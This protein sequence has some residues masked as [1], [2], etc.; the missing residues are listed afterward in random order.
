[1]SWLQEYPL[2]IMALRAILVL[3][4][5]GVFVFTYNLGYKHGQEDSNEQYD[6]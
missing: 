3:L 5:Y 1:M 2:M 6:S 4:A